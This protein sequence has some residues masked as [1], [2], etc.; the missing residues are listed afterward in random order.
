MR[1]LVGDND[2]E[3]RKT[4]ANQLADGGY[5][6]ITS[7]DGA[8]VLRVLQEDNPPKLCVL[9]RDLPVIDGLQI[10]R[11]V[12]EM[13]IRPHIYIVLMISRNPGDQWPDALE[14]G[15]D[16]FVAKPV[17]QFELMARV[18]AGTRIVR[19]EGTFLS[20]LD[21]YESQSV[22]DPLTG[23]W[24]DST[25]TEILRSE[26]ARSARQSVPVSLLLGELSGPPH[27]SESDKHLTADAII[28]E[29]GRRIH[30]S[31]RTYDSV[32]LMGGTTFA[33]VAPGCNADDINR[34][35]ERLLSSLKK[36]TVGLGENAVTLNM[37]FGA[38]TAAAQEDR[39]ADNL[40]DSA[41][42]ALRSAQAKGASRVEA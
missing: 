35:A 30:S 25:I 13:G 18:R 9:D 40:V 8:D 12:R 41:K 4:I 20:F 27:S 42:K 26:L 34:L 11:S 5:E 31:V 21:H 2:A 23:L 39:D 38:A 6:V 24:S 22:T 37:S 19:L 32:G 15:A 29:V 16:E 1:I 7:A 3:T 17:D 14:A 36:F 10:C 33:V 28:R